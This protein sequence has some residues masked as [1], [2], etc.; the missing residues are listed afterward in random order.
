MT[1]LSRDT[2]SELFGAYISTIVFVIALVVAYMFS[3]NNWIRAVSYFL[4]SVEREAKK[5]E[6]KMAKGKLEARRR[7]NEGLHYN[8]TNLIFTSCQF[9]LSL[10][11][12]GDFVKLLI[13]LFTLVQ[14]K[15]MLQKRAYRYVNLV[16]RASF[17]VKG[18]APWERACRHIPNMLAW[19]SR[20]MYILFFSLST[21]SLKWEVLCPWSVSCVELLSYAKVFE[22]EQWLLIYLKTDFEPTSWRK[23]ISE[24][25]N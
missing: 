4:S 15:E 21:G 10:L 2:V 24:N 18:N 20:L 25:K 9:C 7:E 19:W 23:I 13:E 11:T 6:R 16:P 17:N 14:P 5:G 8:P 22:K 3:Y 12:A 1:F